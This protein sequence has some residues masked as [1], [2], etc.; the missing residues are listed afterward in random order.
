MTLKCCDK[1]QQ[2]LMPT[3]LVK[4]HAPLE[5]GVVLST[6][7]PP[8]LDLGRAG[9]RGSQFPMIATL[10]VRVF[11]FGWIFHHQKKYS[12]LYT[13]CKAKKSLE[14]FGAFPIA[15]L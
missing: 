4:M 5:L 8:M 12:E 15:I 3:S 14:Q 2:G 11:V 10:L 9:G 7:A 1:I 13:F 6:S